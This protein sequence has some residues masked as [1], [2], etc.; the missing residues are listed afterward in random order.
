M[1]WIL[2]MLVCFGFSATAWAQNE[3]K[4]KIDGEILPYTIDDCGDT[5]I[6]A[7]LTD[8]SVSVPRKFKTREEYLRYRKYK[9]YALDVHPYAVEAIKIFRELEKETADMKKRHRKKYIRELNK[10]VKEEFKDPLKKLTRTRGYILIKMI[11]REL[12]TPIYYLIKDLRG[13]FNAR[14][15]GIVSGV[16]GYKLKDGYLPDEDPILDA[17]LNDLNISYEVD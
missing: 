4:L 10:R 7:S 2:I 1:R 12:D 13:G 11:E 14:Y 5:L 17:V 3:G 6:L 16:Y 9:R 8:V 15:W